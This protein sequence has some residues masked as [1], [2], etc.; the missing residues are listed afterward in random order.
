[1]NNFWLLVKINLTQLLFNSFLIDKKSS[2]RKKIIMIIIFS[3]ALLYIAGILGYAAYEMGKSLVATN[4]E[5]VLI[6]MAFLLSSIMVFIQVFFSSFNLFFK[7]KDYE[8]LASLPIKQSSII[9]SKMVSFLLYC[10]ALA[11]IFFLPVAIIYFI[12][13][14]VTF[15]SLL[16]TIIGFLL[17][18]LF[19]MFI[20][21]LISLLVYSITIRLRYRNLINFILLL[22]IFIGL[23]ILSQS[24]QDLISNV[25][26]NSQ[27]SFD[28]M[29]NIYFPSIFISK[30]VAYGDWINMLFFILI[31]T[32]PI[33]LAIIFIAWKY[34]FLNSFFA[35]S[36]HVKNKKFKAQEHSIIF[37]LTTKE[38]TRIFT[39]PMVLLNSSAGPLVLFIFAIMSL[40]GGLTGFGFA[41]FLFVLLIIPVANLMASTTSTTFS[42]EGNSFWLLKNLPIDLSQIIISKI[43]AMSIIFIIPNL[44]ASVLIN[45]AFS[46]TILEILIMYGLILS[47]ILLSALLGLTV[48]LNKCNIHWTNEIALVKQSGSVLICMLFGFMIS[49]IPSILYMSFLQPYISGVLFGL[50]LIAI[51]IALISLLIVYLKKKSLILF[52]QIK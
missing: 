13:A 23:F 6:I 39:S 3:I 15:T 26:T 40:T 36:I 11:S 20:G 2:K 50:I 22:G 33:I 34:K 1:M 44:I 5:K 24:T 42:L 29:G 27:S 32:I 30:A 18:P 21:I 48:N 52:N 46:L 45:I 7:S 25:I 37:T 8:Q 17:L 19:P 31:S 38:L 16:F 9:I 43:I 14:G 47:S 41:G 51:Y 12:F 28:I 4:M 35:Q 49:L 10:Y